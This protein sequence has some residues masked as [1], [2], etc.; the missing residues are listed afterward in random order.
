MWDEE[1]L[2]ELESLREE[3]DQEPQPARRSG[4]GGVLI[5]QAALCLLALAA[6]V[7]LKLA[8][9]GRYQRFTDWYRQEAAR[10]IH[11]PDWTQWVRPAEGETES[12]APSATE[13]PP[14]IGSLREI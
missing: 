3:P 14:E 4:G 9:P 11:L 8:E 1:Q 6:L 7:A 2:Q 13:E 5:F 12:P 10:E